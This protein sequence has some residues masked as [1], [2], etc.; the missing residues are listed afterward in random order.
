MNIAYL[1]LAH[2]QPQQMFRMIDRLS[3]DNVCF[4]IHLDNKCKDVELV[5]NKFAGNKKV[6][7]ISNYGIN[8][9]GYNM[10]KATT[11][12]LRLAVNSGVEFKYFILM[13]GQDYPIKPQS[14]I[15]DFYE[16]HN[17]DFFSYNKISY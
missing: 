13:S 6:T 4:F 15:Q 7:V 8:W 16:K 5:K 1:I 9:M 14:Y 17:T 3:A 10:V 11:D 2:N 12:L